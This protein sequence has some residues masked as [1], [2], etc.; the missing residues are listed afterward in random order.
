ME[1]DERESGLTPTHARKG[2]CERCFSVFAVVLFGRFLGLGVCCVS[3]SVLVRGL[4]LTGR[5]IFC[6]RYELDVGLITLHFVTQNVQLINTEIK[7]KR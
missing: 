5:K 6:P 4:R 1:V 3:L 7:L 2:L